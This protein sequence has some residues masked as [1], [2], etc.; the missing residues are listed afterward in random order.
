LGAETPQWHGRRLHPSVGASFHPRR[1][2]LVVV[3]AVGLAVLCTTLLWIA[4]F[5]PERLA[6]LRGVS[7]GAGPAVQCLEDG[8]FTGCDRL[9]DGQM[10]GAGPRGFVMGNVGPWAPLDYFI[11]MPLR[12]VGVSAGDTL[13]LLIAMNAFAFIALIALLWVLVARL[14]GREWGPV[15]TVCIVTSPLLYY[16]TIAFGEVFTAL[17]VV[18]A[19]AAVLT[20]RSPR[21]LALVVMLAGFTKETNAP[22]VAALCCLALVTTVTDRALRRRAFTA[23]GVGT[24]AAVAGNALFN[25]FRFGSV[26]N[27]H[28][29]DS[30]YQVARLRRVGAL[31]VALWIGPN[32]GIVWLWPAVVVL[33]VLL[34]VAGVRATP[35]RTAPVVRWS[36]VLVM[37][38]L[39][40][41][42]LGLARWYSPFGWIAWGSRLVLGLLPAMLLCAIVAL[43][44]VGTAALRR[45]LRSGWSLVVGGIVLLAGIPQV[46]VLWRPKSLSSFFAETQVCTNA[47]V[48]VNAGRYYRCMFAQTWHMPPLLTRVVSDLHSSAGIALSALVVLTGAA[49]VVLARDLAGAGTGQAHH[50]KTSSR[51]LPSVS[52][53]DL[54]REISVS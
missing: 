13:S 23:I 3:S 27:S 42:M 31:F 11:A 45:V 50:A 32:T 7:M 14:A 26:F 8:R 51:P 2:Q 12:A 10:S 48:E 9:P 37:A 19:V 28:Y 35:G 25:V 22:F 30:V 4:V 53:E 44:P 46:A 40:G 43:G 33:L 1:E 16:S 15:V 34:A 38:L 24:S 49:L 36:G 29:S 17:G 47:A 5:R 18:A 39:V 20:R 54:S 52:D 21:V 41:Q 6:D